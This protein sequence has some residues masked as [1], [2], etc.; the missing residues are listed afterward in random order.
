MQKSGL[1]NWHIYIYSKTPI[2]TSRLSQMISKI[3]E[4]PPVVT[5]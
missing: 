4:T 2:D 1:S 5:H 3:F